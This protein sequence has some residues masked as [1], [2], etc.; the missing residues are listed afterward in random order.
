[1]IEEVSSL[2]REVGSSIILP[3]FRRLRAEEIEEKG[4]ADPVT[5]ADREAEQAIASHLLNLL[6]GS[7]VIGEEACSVD[8]RLLDRLHGNSVWVI[9]PIDGT[10]NFVAGRAPFA[11]MVALLQDGEVVMSWIHDPLTGGTAC[12]ERGS[13][14]WLDGQRLAASAYGGEKLSG[15]ISRFCLPDNHAP[16]VA[17]VEQLAA[18]VMPTRRCAGAEYPM[19]AQGA[20]DFAVY[21][22]TLVWD[23]AAG[24]L[25]LRESGGVVCRLDGTDYSPVRS[26]VGL[27]LA[28][29]PDVADE[30]L[31][32]R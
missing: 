11:I 18:R 12:A 6:P 30:L 24:S 21:W 28:R 10:G 25:L 4:P 13:G 9:D 27:M 20:C 15:I 8:P 3:R 19:V 17:R 23:H 29:S 14:A 31:R 22:R 5:I 1:M 16:F 26:G 32:L 7:C 2:L